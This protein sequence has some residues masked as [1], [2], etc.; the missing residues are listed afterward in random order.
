MRLRGQ[1]VLRVS[2]AATLVVVALYPAWRLVEVVSS[3]LGPIIRALAGPRAVRPM[4]NTVGLALAVTLGA[5]IVG[6]VAAIVVQRS[7]RRLLAVA[8][9]SPLLVP[10]FVSALSFVD[11]YTTGGLT[12]D[13]FG[14]RIPG[15]FGPVGVAVV[16]VVNAAPIVF[17][18]VTAGLAAGREPDLI[19]AA[20]ASGARPWT[21]T[22][23]IT[24]PLI[25][26]SILGAG[27]VVTVVTANAYGVPAVLGIPAGF[28][29]VTTQ[30]Q[31]ELA[32]SADPAAFHRAIG[33]SIVLVGLALMMAVTV[34]RR[35]RPPA[36]TT[37]APAPR[38][39]P[40]RLRGLSAA[41]WGY[42][43]VGVVIPTAALG[44]RSVVRAVGLS[45]HP[46]NWTLDHFQS[47]W[48]PLAVRAA[49]NTTV[50]ALGAATLC[51]VLGAALVGLRGTRLARWLEA[52]PIASFAVPGSALAVAVLLAY[53]PGLRDTVGLVMVAYVGKFWVLAHRPILGAVDRIPPGLRQAAAASGAHSTEITRRIVGPLLR[54]ALSGAWLVVFVFALHEVTMSVLLFGP[55][56]ETL[57]SVILNIRQLG[58]P[59][60]TAALAV[61]ITAAVVVAGLP[62]IA[63]WWR[64]SEVGST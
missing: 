41:L 12:D 11:A 13:L 17:L 3:D 37:P 57:A 9:M 45:P 25:R 16:L 47:A 55:G 4:L 53:S 8:M 14:L 40:M 58:D 51:V 23:R 52:I 5:L 59:S 50:L 31:R 29:T 42:W 49:V 22:R 32:F 7:G 44:L 21:A 15:I 2:V 1:T 30:I 60:T 56:S 36:D 33:L 46:T 43:T 62:V 63:G 28:E 38:R 27:A 20:R 10:P 18:I 61:S 19:E 6:T 26:R 34:E 24:L 54:P 64:R 39:R 48:S 35:W